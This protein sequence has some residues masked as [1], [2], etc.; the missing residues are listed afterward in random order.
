MLSFS[1]PRLLLLA[2]AV[3]VAAL[4][5]CSAQ[6]ELR[7]DNTGPVRS[8]GT[9][10]ITREVIIGEGRL[11]TL[12]ASSLQAMVGAY[13]TIVVGDVLGAT[14]RTCADVPFA[15]DETPLPTEPPVRPPTD[16]PKYNRPTPDCTQ[17]GPTATDYSVGV[18]RSLRSGVQAG[19]VI[20][21]AQA[22][23]VRNGVAYSLENDP[24]IRVG[25]RYLFFLRFQGGHYAG[26]PFGRFEV[27]ASGRLAVADEVWR[28]LPAVSRLAGRSVDEAVG[29]ITAALSAPSSN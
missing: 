21:V 26:P 22:G 10:P 29:E 14:D 19:A 25:G 8:S 16:H 5:G 6:S 27:D 23:G 28:Y 17:A 1:G 3:P 7:G 15:I 2:L 24:V 13:D 4:V 18:V 9:Q 11:P 20:P 12:N